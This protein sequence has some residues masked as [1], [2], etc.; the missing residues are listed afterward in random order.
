MTKGFKE[1]FATLLF[2]V[3]VALYFSSYYYLYQ[4]GRFTFFQAF[5]ESK[6]KFGYYCQSNSENRM[7]NDNLV[8]YAFYP[9]A[10][11]HRLIDP[12]EWKIVHTF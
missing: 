10:H 7:I 4:S 6:I 11:I 12:K 5:G 3:I 8:V 1:N 2:V 9:I